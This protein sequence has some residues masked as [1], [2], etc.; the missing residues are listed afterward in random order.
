[1]FEICG[2]NECKG[3]IFY[4]DG[5]KQC[6]KL[7]ECP[8]AKPCGNN[9]CEGKIICR[10]GVKQCSELT[11]C[12]GAKPCVESGCEGKITYVNG[13]LPYCSR[14]ES[15]PNPII[16]ENTGCT[17]ISYPVSVFYCDRPDGIGRVIWGCRNP[18]CRIIPDFIDN[19]YDSSD[20]DWYDGE[21]P[22]DGE[23]SSDDED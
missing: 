11:N 19:G 7:T 21:N 13:G 14:N 12:P 8:G 4:V 2:E 6:S 17:S 3:Q 23:N 15:C 20:E 9:E 5:I 1:M 18:D 10:Y 16:C 22:S